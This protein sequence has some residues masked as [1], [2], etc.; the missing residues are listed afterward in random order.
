MSKDQ[1]I[2][3]PEEYSRRKLNALYREIPLK[4][5]TSRLLRKYF[6]AMAMLYGIIPL[7]MAKDIIF[8]LSPRLVTEAE[9]FAFAEIARHECECYFILGKEELFQNVGRTKP[10]D[11]MLI[12]VSLLDESG[13][14]INEIT[15]LQ[16]GKPFYIPDKKQLL[17]YDDPYYCED[18][19]EKL[20]LV[21]FLK[22][23][24]ALDDDRARVLIGLFVCSI[25]SVD[26]K[27]E[28]IFDYME[29][30]DVRFKSSRD[31]ERF[32]NLFNDFHNST[33]MPCNCGHTPIEISKMIPSKNCVKSLTLGPNI[34][35]SLQTGE[36]DIEDLR[37][38][39]L[40][41]ELPSEEIRLDILKQ[42]NEINPDE[43]EKEQYKVGRNDPCPC[44]S[45][46]KY[47]KCCGK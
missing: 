21:D 18:T 17:E 26:F 4:D 16:A 35:K 36:M 47:K 6:N 9:F 19:P 30:M 28:D 24:C 3:F 7:R 11:R 33:R 13:D 10:F 2:E 41:A 27:Y 34:L 31:E 45:G 20:S 5:S 46:K 38:Q 29:S 14:N 37:R 12:D 42:L 40:A 15:C 8:S 23:R 22:K 1:Y 39:I 43:P 25:R 44:G 32:L